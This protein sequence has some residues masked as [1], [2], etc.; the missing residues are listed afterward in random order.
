MTT[1]ARIFFVET[2]NIEW[3]YVNDAFKDCMDHQQLIQP[4]IV[5]VPRHKNGKAD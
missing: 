3:K 4:I 2:Q 5:I 1:M